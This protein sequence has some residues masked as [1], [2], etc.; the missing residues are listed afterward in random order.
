MLEKSV[1]HF[2]ASQA[3]GHIGK[4]PAFLRKCPLTGLNER[5]G[6]IEGAYAMLIILLRP[7]PSQRPILHNDKQFM[8]TELPDLRQQ[9]YTVPY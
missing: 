5:G 2:P 4:D 1:Q 8:G 6:I 7:C 9:F 3:S